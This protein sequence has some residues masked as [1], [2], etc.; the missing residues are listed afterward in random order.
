MFSTVPIKITAND[1]CH[2]DGFL[3]PIIG[4]PGAAGWDVIAQEDFT[5]TA[6]EITSVNL[7][8]KAEFPPGYGVIFLPRSGLGSN[9]TVCFANTAPLIDS[10]YRGFWTLNMHLKKVRGLKQKS[11]GE[12]YHVKRGDK[13]AQALIVPVLHPEFLYVHQDDLSESVRGDGGFGSTDKKLA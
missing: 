10:D 11:A 4:S 2:P 1:N 9:Y 6:D 7:Q 13:I 12:E 5:L 3:K 8:F